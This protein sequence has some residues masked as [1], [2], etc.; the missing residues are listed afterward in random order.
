[1]SEHK[2][3]SPVADD[4]KAH[5]K[6]GKIVSADEAVRLIRDGDTVAL[7]GVMGG[8]TPDEL[9]IAL[10]KRFMESGEPRGLTLLYASGIGDGKDKGVNRIAHEGLL[11]RVVAGHWALTPKMQKIAIGEKIEAYNF[12]QGV[13]SHMFRDIAAGNPRTISSVGLGTFVDPRLG[14]G[15]INAM[16]KEDLVEIITFDG[17][18]YLAYRTM[19][20][21]VAFL[22]GTTADMDGN[23][24]MEREAMTLEVLPIAMAA[25]NSGGFVIVQVERIADRG[26]LNPRHVKIPGILVD[27]VVVARPENHWQTYGTPYNPAFSCE[28]KV[29][30]A[31]VAPLEMDDRKI[32]ARRAAFEL[33]PNMVVNLGIGMPEGV[34][35]VANEEGIFEYLTLTAEAGSI[36][37]IPAGGQNFGAATNM[38]CL[39][40]MHHQFDFYDGGGLDLACLGLAQMDRHGNVNVSRF[41]PRLAGCGGFIDISQ[42]SKKMVFV[43]TFTAGGTKVAADDGKLRI[44]REGGVKKF[45]NEVEQVTFSGKTARMNNLDVLFVTER[46]VFT[47]TDEGVELTE[48]APGVD[49]E[50]DILAYMDFKPIVKNPKKMDERIFRLPPMDLKK[51]LLGKP[52][53][54]RMA[55]DPATNIFFVNFEGL[56][57]RSMADIEEIRS[58]AEAL[59]IPL[60]RKVDAIVNYDNFSIVPELADA[61][62]EVVKTIVS[63]FYEHVTRYTTSAFLRMKLGEGMNARGLAPHIYES[64]GEAR[65]GLKS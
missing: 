49:L 52:M 62:I 65:K 63:R 3:V 47:L 28:F 48:I 22:R 18:E 42:N 5:M 7:D 21:Q 35:S 39:L 38:D 40:D 15:K 13:L 45:V 54:E 37:G 50:K 32:I 61:Y 41:G 30:A 14:G 46:C 58:Q 26:A 4:I 51:D 16:T 31:S 53:S 36:G 29:P 2:I 1:M 44:V 19:P 25:K 60:G 59:L 55:Y 64:R 10:E 20:V 23:I 33:R 9:I 34:A 24:T 17:K 56:H 27:C 8:G 12:P 43:G 57:V 11:K 6:R